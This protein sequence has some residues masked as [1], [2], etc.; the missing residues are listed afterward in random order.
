MF[1]FCFSIRR[2]FLLGVSLGRLLEL[3][4]GA[5]LVRALSQLL[6]EYEH[7]IAHE[8]RKTTISLKKNAACVFFHCSFGTYIH[9][10]SYYIRFNCYI[11][12]HFIQKEKEKSSK[13]APNLS[14]YSH[15]HGHTLINASS[16]R[17]MDGNEPIKATLHK[18]GKNVVY[19][20][21]QIP[22]TCMAES[23]TFWKQYLHYYLF[24]LLWHVA[25]SSCFM[26]YHIFI[27]GFCF[28][29][30]FFTFLLFL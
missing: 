24:L 20:Y 27:T 18:V 8:V 12:Y 2:W 26:L 10:M 5:T 13:N 17:N 28:C 6:E 21:L 4:D 14:N 23:M 16:V 11:C 30:V 22:F 29:S 25:L 19:E 9:L 1:F 3:A 7:Y 15:Y